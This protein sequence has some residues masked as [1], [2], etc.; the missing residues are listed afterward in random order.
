MKMLKVVASALLCALFV[1]NCHAAPPAEAPHKLKAD[2]GE[3]ANAAAVLAASI[4]AEGVARAAADSAEAITRAAG[5]AVRVQVASKSFTLSTITAM[6]AFNV[7]SLNFDAALP[8][9]AR[10]I[11]AEIETTT[12][13][14]NVGDTARMLGAIGRGGGN[15]YDFMGPQTMSAIRLVGVAGGQGKATT[16]YTGA[17]I[18][19]VT[20][21]VVFDSEVPDINMSTFSAGAGIARV[22]YFVMP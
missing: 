22:Y 11:G 18:G 14:Q 6:G 20:P 3:G 2:H 13:I 1:L 19:G 10:F 21:V 12:K 7:G 8:A 5:D 4:T 17:A 16:G 9:N 15:Y